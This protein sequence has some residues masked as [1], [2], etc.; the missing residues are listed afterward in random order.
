MYIIDSS[1]GGPGNKSMKKD[2]TKLHR[3]QVLQD[4]YQNGGILMIGYDLM[5]NLTQSDKTDYN[6]KGNTPT[7]DSN[8]DNNSA[9]S[10]SSSA[11]NKP[12]ASMEELFKKYL[13]NPGPDIIVADE[14]HQIKNPKAR[15]SVIL[16]KVKTPLRIA[17]TGSP[18]QNNLI[19]YWCMVNWIK[20]YHLG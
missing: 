12:K 6:S 16:G 1:D 4:W 14:A 19:E 3:L 17:L 11:K 8:F 13:I 2:S 10:N 18:L 20:P 9:S 7:V 5:S 15:K